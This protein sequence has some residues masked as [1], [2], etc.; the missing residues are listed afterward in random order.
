MAANGDLAATVR[1][2]I[3]V[4]VSRLLKIDEELLAPDAGLADFGFDSIALKEF[5]VRLS[6]EYGVSISPA[7]FFARGTI[8]AV[9]QYLAE[10]HPAETTARHAA[11]EASTPV[12]AAIKPAAV[13]IS[14][15]F[16]RRW[17][18]PGR[19]RRDRHERALSRLA[20]SRRLLAQPGG[21]D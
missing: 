12:P 20:R 7:V 3:T 21:R 6:D 19:H 17:L 4:L 2:N 11:A 15:A 18:L 10:T 14:A 13:S 1:R 5:A 8:D 9:A 16:R